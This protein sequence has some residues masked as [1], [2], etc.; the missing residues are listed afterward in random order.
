MTSYADE[1][2]LTWEHLRA[3]TAATIGWAMDAFDYFIVVLV[4]ADIAKDF[5]VSLTRMAFLTTVTLLMRPVGAALFGLWAD[6]VGRK[7][8]LM[9]DVA[10]YSVVGF[11]CAFAPNYSTLLVLRLLYGIGMG[12]EWGLGAS[13]A[14][15]KVPPRHRGLISGILQQG[16]SVGY[17]F[18]A[19]AYLVISNVTDWGWRGL[20]ALSILPAL[21]SLFVR[22][23]V[24]ESET[25]QETRA[26]AQRNRTTVRQILSSGPVLRR[27]VYLVLLMTAFNWMSHG[28]QDV[29]PTYLKDGLHFAPN[30]ALY[31]AMLY[32]VGALIGGTV[33]GALSERVG[34]RVVVVVCAVLGLPILPLFAA[35]STL[36]LVCLGSFLMQI[37][38]QGAWGVIPA[39]LTELS[40]A[41]IRGFYPGVTY[42]LGNCLAAFNLPI[43]ER[44]ADSHSYT[45]ALVATMVPVFVAVAVLAAI[46]KE[47][48]GG[49]LSRGEVPTVAAGGRAP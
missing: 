43:Q 14:M 46:G 44:L 4:Y 27:L 35:S 24:S 3:V 36:G 13:L 42:Q 41:E 30:T 17:L 15:E 1:D 32:N 20:F 21:L 39:H 12:G 7:K 40:P 23:K 47:A 5:G 9:I 26:N 16:Y 25:W 31:I 18:A 37:V 11:L 38:V 34:R 2:R 6:R 45:F 49:Q 10:F 22:A 28:T 8:V 33:M 29:Y 48:R 19:A